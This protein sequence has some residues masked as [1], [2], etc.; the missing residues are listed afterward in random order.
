VKKEKLLKI[1]LKNQQSEINEHHVYNNLAKLAKH[2]KNKKVLQHIAK[3]ELRHYNFWK[4]HTKQSFRPQKLEVLKYTLL[5]R[6]FG[7]I[8]GLKLMERGENLAKK[9]YRNLE[10]YYPGA[11]KISKDETQHEKTL[12]NLIKEERLDYVGSIVLGINDALVELTGVLAGLTLV[13]QSAN[14]VGIASLITGIAASLSM[15]SSEYLSIKSEKT[16]KT[17]VKAAFYTGFAYL[18]TV[19]F[20][21]FPYFIFENVFHSL[22]LTITN[23][24]IV[25]LLYTF[26]M[27]VARDISFKR[28]FLEM[29]LISMGV[30]TLSFAIGFLIRTFIGIDI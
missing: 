28:R 23:A 16:T 27:S 3:D 17:P 30:A 15:A 29:F 24:I 11:L 22:A 20:L 25:I 1:I 6:I 21:I 26:Y 2:K 19:L 13:F 9:H 12:I 14:I 5:A 10:K 4:K 7:L 18:I 8:F